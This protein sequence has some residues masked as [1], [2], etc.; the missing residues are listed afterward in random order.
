MLRGTTLH[1]RFAARRAA[2]RALHRS[3]PGWDGVRLV[4]WA[5]LAPEL[6]VERLLGGVPSAFC[7]VSQRP[8]V[9]AARTEDT[10]VIDARGYEVVTGPQDWPQIDV[11]VKGFVIPRPGVLER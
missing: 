7:D 9:Q 11:A 3:S 4:E 5:A 1:A 2:K 10:V 8:S 6:V